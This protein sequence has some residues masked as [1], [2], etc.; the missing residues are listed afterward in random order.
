MNLI[1]AD[2]FS[3]FKAKGLSNRV[4]IKEKLNASEKKQFNDFVSD[5]KNLKL[6]Q[7]LTQYY[8]LILFVLLY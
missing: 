8:F 4:K 1:M 7:N 3:E 6:F 5:S 2:F